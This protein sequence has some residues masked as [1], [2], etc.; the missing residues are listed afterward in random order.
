M[1]T[2]YQQLSLEDR[3]TIARLHAEGRSLRQIAA[4]VDCAPSTVSRELK[5]NTSRQKGYQ[6]AYAEEQTRARR[7]KGS[8][9][10]R[11]PELR[12]LVLNHLK[13]QWSP[14]QIAGR[15]QSEAGVCVISHE[16]IYRFIYAQLTRTNDSTWRNYLPRAKTRRGY[17]G[18]K[19]G[20]PANFIK[21][22]VSIH[23]RPQDVEDRSAIGN[24]ESDF[25]LFS[26]YGQ[27]VLA[28][29]DRNSRILL[30]TRP[31]NRTAAPDVKTIYAGGHGFARPAQGIGRNNNIQS[32]AGGRRSLGF[33]EIAND[34]AFHLSAT[35]TGIAGPARPRHCFLKCSFLAI[36]LQPFFSGKAALM[37]VREN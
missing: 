15:L 37:G 10:D 16:T 24:W 9:L 8:K 13:R 2:R 30:A 19:G 34:F 4:G 32:I 27:S 3:C 25:I 6:P 1:G 11:S 18:P 29:H 31:K 35:R 12:D 7:W 36:G 26:K 17:R 14:E 21:D 33:H 20:S 5:R 23:Q 22:R 28:L